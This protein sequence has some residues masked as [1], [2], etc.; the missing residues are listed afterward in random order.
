MFLNVL[1]E[2]YFLV[3]IDSNFVLG[4]ETI[5]ECVA[6]GRLHVVNFQGEFTKPPLSLIIQH[7]AHFKP[8]LSTQEEV[9][10]DV[11]SPVYTAWYLKCFKSCN[12]VQR[13]QFW[14]G[15]YFTRAKALVQHV[16]MLW[17]FRLSWAFLARRNSPFSPPTCGL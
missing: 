1:E 8:N 16:K 12:F 7:S 3:S 14:S 13:K 6:S 5:A 10:K 4:H 9:N 15:P 2:I 17:Q 11:R